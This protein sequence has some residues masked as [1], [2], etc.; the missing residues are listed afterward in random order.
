M[1]PSDLARYRE[2]RQAEVDSAFIY[3]TLAE[4]EESEP[5][6][7][8]Y[9]R[10]A[11]TEERDADVWRTRLRAAGAEPSG[12]APSRRARILVWLAK[13]LGPEYVLPTLAE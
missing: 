2:Y 13:R 6:A 4:L 7:E 3:R 12:A 8:V 1:P 5:L 11:A 10:L 9:R